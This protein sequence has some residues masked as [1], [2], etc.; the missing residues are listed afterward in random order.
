MSNT[1]DC[2]HTSDV[3]TISEG[4]LQTCNRCGQQIIITPDHKEKIIK[5]GEINGVRTNIHPLANHST[6]QEPGGGEAPP[7]P[8]V[9]PKPK[10]RKEL[11]RYYETN[12]EALLAD[13]HSMLLRDFRLKWHLSTSYWG[14]LKLKWNVK[15]KHPRKSG[16][17]MA[18]VMVPVNALPPLPPFSDKWTEA[19]QVEWLRTYRE[20]RLA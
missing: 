1:I 8:L 14:K 7:P 5:R 9:P 12:K 19:V 18:S 16:N 20:L 11:A 4:D 13:Y 3:K 6:G 2:Q 15:G 10:K 17:P